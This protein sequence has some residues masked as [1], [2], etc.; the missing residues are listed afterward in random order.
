MSE[1]YPADKYS[2]AD[3]GLLLS[4]RLR[5][6]TSVI[7]E[8]PFVRVADFEEKIKVLL[9]LAQEANN[10][11]DEAAA[12]KDVKQQYVVGNYYEGLGVYAGQRDK[13]LEMGM[14][15]VFVRAVYP[16]DDTK[17]M[18][19]K[20]AG[21]KNG[22]WVSFMLNRENNI[23]DLYAFLRMTLGR[24]PIFSAYSDFV[25]GNSSTQPPD[26]VLY[27]QKVQ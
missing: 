19:L 22:E 2:S 16:P 17:T 21:N 13:V 27:C 15:D 8:L 18:A 3:L 20:C 11:N 12:R 6:L 24:H 1:R 26:V 5:R 25:V 23:Q 9:G 4:A 7:G 14:A 10:I